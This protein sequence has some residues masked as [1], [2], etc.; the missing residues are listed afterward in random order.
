MPFNLR[1]IPGLALLLISVPTSTVLGQS[2]PQPHVESIRI[3]SDILDAERTVWV[4][5]PPTYQHS[6]VAYPVLYLL[7]GETHL[8]HAMGLLQ[9]TSLYLRTPEMIVVAIPHPNR[10]QDLIPALDT[11]RSADGQIAV[12]SP[13]F[14]RF[15]T[16]ELRPFIDNHYRTQPFTLLAGHSLGGL[17]A[18]SAFVDAAATFNAVLAIS[19]SLYWNDHEVLNRARE[20]LPRT[21][22]HTRFLYVAMAEAEPPRIAESTR[23]LVAALEENASPELWW[24]FDE[25]PND[26]HL[27]VPYEALHRGLRAIFSDWTL[28]PTGLTSRMA[29]TQSLEPLD[30]HYRTVS[31]HYG[32]EARTPELV[33]SMVGDRLL[34]D[35]VPLAIEMFR[36][37]VSVYPNSP[38]AHDELGRGLEIAGQIDEAIRS[39]ERAAALAQSQNHPR[40]AAIGERLARARS[41]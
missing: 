7:D 15:L 38:E 31:D 21:N 11:S 3:R 10:S 32:F 22:G 35:N 8:P 26:N 40:L 1:N 16:D 33:F 20:T 19:P 28:P 24:Q 29:Q 23:E 6:G 39:Y 25:F 9:F 2:S 5:T 4:S 14:L 12:Q 18:V 17:F 34:S 41:Q 36:R 37:R 13:R 27:T 30:E